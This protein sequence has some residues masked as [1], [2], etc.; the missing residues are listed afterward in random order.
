MFGFVTIQQQNL[1]CKEIVFH[2]LVLTFKLPFIVDLDSF[3]M[4][5]EY[6]SLILY[7]YITNHL[8]TSLIMPRIQNIFRYFL[9]NCFILHSNQQHMIILKSLYPHQHV[10]L[11]VLFI[12]AISVVLKWHL[13]VFFIWSAG[14]Q[15]QDLGHEINTVS[16]LLYTQPL[17]EW[18][19]IVHDDQ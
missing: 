6:K 19:R 3:F 2:F 13:I 11:F 10:L 18:F 16:E 8:F 12:T 1:N 5:S 17:S 4:H 15:T 9:G 7:S 14:D